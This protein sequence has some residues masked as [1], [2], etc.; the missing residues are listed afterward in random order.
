MGILK[1]YIAAIV[2][3]RDLGMLLVAVI[4]YSTIDLRNFRPTLLGKANSVSQVVAIGFVLLSL[5]PGLTWDQ[6]WILSARNVALDTTI[7]LTVL[8]GFHYG[9][10]VSQRIGEVIGD[11]S[12]TEEP[13]VVSMASARH[14]AA[15]QVSQPR[16]TH[17]KKLPKGELA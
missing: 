3:S 13:G 8:S 1:P 15:K 17:S 14:P 16:R 6:S 11:V 4:L 12:R 7:L 2:F 5:A 9:W 10:V